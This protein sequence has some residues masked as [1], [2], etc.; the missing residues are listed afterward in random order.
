[1]SAFIEKELAT[2]IQKIERLIWGHSLCVYVP[3]RHSIIYGCI[4]DRI[5]SHSIFCEYKL[6]N[7]SCARLHVKHADARKF[8]DDYDLLGVLLHLGDYELHIA[9]GIRTD[10]T[11]IPA[12]GT[13]FIIPFNLSSNCFNDGNDSRFNVAEMDNPIVAMIFI[14]Q[15]NEIH[16]FTFSNEHIII[17]SK[18]MKLKYIR[19]LIRFSKNYLFKDYVL[20]YMESEDVLLSVGGYENSSIVS[21]D[22]NDRR[23]E[24]KIIGKLPF[25]IVMDICHHALLF[26][27]DILIVIHL[28]RGNI[29]C[30]DVNELDNWYM[31][32]DGCPITQSDSNVVWCFVD[33]EKMVNLIHIPQLPTFSSLIQ[34]K[35]TNK[36]FYAPIR[37]LIPNEL[38]EVKAKKTRKHWLL[39]M[40]YL[41][42]EENKLLDK[43]IVCSLKALIADYCMSFYVI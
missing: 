21:L 33:N 6:K 24:W 2:D 10:D 41:R 22:L 11:N 23:S 12:D 18:S 37:S 9:F 43:D 13:P 26:N 7:K 36:H 38:R 34:F 15:R 39:I 30:A 16:L 19:N 27:N 28:W 3:N 31:I 8:K 1:M 25:E 5:D 29:W 42:E 40:G 17:D 20:V 35:R 4:E 32:K 14:P